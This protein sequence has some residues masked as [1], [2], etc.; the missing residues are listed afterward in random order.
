MKDQ[1]GSLFAEQIIREKKRHLKTNLIASE[2]TQLHTRRLVVFVILLIV[3]MGL[4]FT[5]LFTLT[6]VEGQRYR[7]I[8][9]GNRIREQK[10]QASRGVIYD[11]NEVP[12][13]RN[14]PMFVSTSGE[15]FF[16]SIPST[17]SGTMREVIAREYIYADAMAHVL[18]YTSE[19]S[20]YEL[21]Y[22]NQKGAI[23]KIKTDKKLYK[24]GDI[25]GKGGIE[26][27]YDGILSG[28]DGKE[29]VEVD[30]LGNLVR[31]LGRVEPAVGGNIHL[32][33]DITLQKIA[34][35]VLS[36]KKGAIVVTNPTTGEVL[37]LYSSPSF[38]PNQF[39]RD[40]NVESLLTDSDR[41]LFNRAI[42][43]L[44]PP[45]SIFKIITA[46]AALEEG[47]ITKDTQFED[48]GVLTVGEF[49]FG[50]WYFSQYGKKEGLLDIVGALRR[51]NDIFFYKIGEL[52]GIEKI[53]SWAR[54]FGIG[55]TL[56]LDIDGEEEGVMPDPFWMREVKGENW[57][58][59]N[60]YHVAIGQGDI[61]VTP[62][63]VNS[64]TN[65]IANGG[66]LCRPYIAKSLGGKCVDINIQKETVNLIRKGM[67]LACSPGGT[68]WPLFNF[69]VKNEKL[70]ADGVDFLEPVSA[71][72]S[73]KLTV[74]VPIGCKTGT[75]EFGDPKN[76]THA[77]ITVFA[78]VIHPQ[79]SVTVLVEGAGEGSSVAGPI[80]KKI[81]EGWFGK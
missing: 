53:A 58:L 43:G 14:I 20:Q 34:K 23:S 60:T 33:L 48:T 51:S 42:S 16:E 54:K 30:A 76:R 70:K 29:L 22:F 63:Q 37:S 75:A 65:L 13:V 73:A 47:V 4:L 57:Y 36:G 26:K 8:A 3:G 25:V 55:N 67:V 61:L 44:Y 68:G 6:V 72:N 17:A 5:K 11:R 19:I 71:T 79:I 56:G 40:S 10:I 81:L 2:G 1:L 77:W 64:W 18:G 80:A 45:G 46:T 24:T 9:E 62:L 35:D 7:K 39:I 69:G 38:D 27:S 41:P 15:Q 49:S 28:R 66:K 12:L 21:D 32:T 52:T 74:T 31:V 59:G 78:P 50:N